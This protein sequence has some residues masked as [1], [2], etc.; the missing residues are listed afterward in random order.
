MAAAQSC[1]DLYLLL[2]RDGKLLLALREGTGY[3]DGMWNCP[4]GKLE[5]DEDAL[6][7]LI[8][9]SD[10]EVG[11]RLGRDDVALVAVVH[12]LS[13][14]RV[15]RV[16]LFFAAS[17]KEHLGEPYNA[18]PHKCAQLSW[19]ASD[20]LPANTQPVT[21]LGVDLYRRGVPYASLGWD[22]TPPW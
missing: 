3:C 20:Q 22:G 1:V 21:A 11:V 13:P 15:S 19:F 5:D 4:S 2:E 9:E 7:G 17:A 10:E 6:E 12:S 18:E 8:R 16:A 14:E